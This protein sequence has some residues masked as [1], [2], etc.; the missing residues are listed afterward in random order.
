MFKPRRIV[1]GLLAALTMAFA[2]HAQPG[3]AKSTSPQVIAAIFHADWCGSCKKMGPDVMK[4]MQG[5]K[6]DGNVKF[7]KFDLT[8][9]ATKKQS[10]A[11]AA[12]NGIT[13]VYNS[14]G[15]TGMV[16]LVD[17]KTRKVIGK[18][19]SNDSQAEMKEKI[20]AAK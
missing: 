10:K 19:D 9:D 13:P 20:E 5:Y 1:V 12:R 15:K 11:L 16:L 3:Q 18:I 6:G 4:T 14:Y 7:V 2:L 17:G 8:N